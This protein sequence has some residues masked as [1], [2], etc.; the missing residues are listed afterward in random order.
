MVS[1]IPPLEL[2]SQPPASCH[3]ATLLDPEGRKQLALR[4]LGGEPIARL[5]DRLAVS[6]KF[7][8]RQAGK[9]SSAVDAAFQPPPGDDGV[10]FRIPVTREWI[11]EV[12]LCGYLHCHGSYRGVQA[13][14]RDACDFELS[15]GS[16][17]NI[18][19]AAIEGA[20]LVHRQEDLRTIRVGAHD[21]IF[22]GDPVLVGV[23]PL[24]T[25]CYLLAQEPG[26]DGTTWGVHLLDLS[27]RGLSPEYTVADAGKGLRAGQAQAWPG[28]PCR[29]DVF[30][31]ERQM[32]QM[33]AY[34]DNRAYGCIGTREKVERQMERARN[35]GRGQAF[36][37][38]LA[39]ARQEETTA[40][41]LAA[42]LDTLAQ[43]LREDVLSLTGPDAPTRHE[44]F[45]FIVSQMQAREHLAPHRI[46]PVRVALEN[47]RDELLAFAEDLDR[48][49][50]AAARKHQVPLR[51]V[52][53][54]FEMGRLA[55][56]APGY[57][58]KDAALW[59]RLGPRY[60][61]VRA[62]VEAVAQNTVRAS[63]MVENLNSRL[64]CYFFL[65]REV[66]PAYLDL[67]RFFLNH[68]RYPRSRKDPR[69]GKSPAEILHGR[70]FPHWLEQLGFTRFR[71]AA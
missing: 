70:A 7:V 50:A 56:V 2:E 3:G 52:R 4:A 42:D 22:Q 33:A 19:A 63:S 1:V 9:A 69:A 54:V 20:R 10:L 57:W 15:V 61:A 36:S 53:E 17:H 32:G 68:R 30:H 59:E 12:V 26:R 25:Y 44:L 21:E 64:R 55:P 27:E 13:F 66:G 40:V 31:A 6:R 60:P 43:W 58:Q 18:V 47:Q 46:H 28:V 62:A 35:R 5:A 14:L 16:I 39:L 11:E 45:D 71:R 41:T 67:L 29:G 51:D 65:R 24:S 37:K 49:L 8:Y 48:Q 38:R 23:D 34:L